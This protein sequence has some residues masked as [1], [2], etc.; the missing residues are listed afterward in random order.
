MHTSTLKG[1][2]SQCDCISTQGSTLSQNSPETGM[3]ASRM[4]EFSV[5]GGLCM[6]AQQPQVRGTAEGVPTLEGVRAPFNPEKLWLLDIC[7]P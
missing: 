6:K 4:S 2:S 1:K 7:W 3:A 5:P